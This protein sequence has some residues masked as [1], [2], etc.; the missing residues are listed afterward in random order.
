MSKHTAESAPWAYVRHVA[1]NGVE[2]FSIVPAG[3]EKFW[4]SWTIAGLCHAVNDEANARHI[5][6]CVNACAGYHAQDI[7]ACGVQL[8]DGNETQTA[9]IA[10]QRDE[11]LA[12][13]ERVV[14]TP[15]NVEGY[16]SHEAV[17]LRFVGL[18]SEA[19]AAIARV[20]AG[21]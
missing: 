1:P 17:R 12:A 7:E 5:V 2:S 14:A 8:A 9:A 15:V 10:K 20:K 13:L 16:N 6:T 21:A 18:Q 3:R 11:L 4:E 19:R